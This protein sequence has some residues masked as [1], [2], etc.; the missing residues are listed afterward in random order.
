[1]Q[2]EEVQ[3]ASMENPF[4]EKCYKKKQRNGVVAGR[5]VASKVLFMPNSRYNSMLSY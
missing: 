5:V 1:M 4:Q 3:T 2:E